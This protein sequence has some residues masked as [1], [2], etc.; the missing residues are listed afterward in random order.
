MYTTNIRWFVVQVQIPFF[1]FFYYERR[2]SINTK[3]TLK[4]F[5]GSKKEL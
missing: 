3:I 1:L 2:V 4:K 5:R